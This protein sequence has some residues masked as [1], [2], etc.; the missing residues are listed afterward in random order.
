MTGLT[1]SI[2]DIL[3]RRISGEL[4]DAGELRVSKTS[5]GRKRHGE[6]YLVYLPLNRNYLWQTLHE[7]GVKVRVFI[8]IPGEALK[9]KNVNKES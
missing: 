1:W 6:R 4:V 8:E 3:K 7:S 5:L 2:Q 9:E